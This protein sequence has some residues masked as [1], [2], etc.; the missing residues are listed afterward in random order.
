[1]THWGQGP[2]K[3]DKAENIPTGVDKVAQQGSMFTI[4]SLLNINI[5]PRIYM[6]EGTS[7]LSKVL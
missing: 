1:M 7:Q 4:T 6:V 3:L 5:I 2:T